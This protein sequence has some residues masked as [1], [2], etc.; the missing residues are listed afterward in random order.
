M[1]EPPKK[2]N[3]S[4]YRCDT[5]F[6]LDPILEMFCEENLIGICLVSGEELRIYTISITGTHI[7]PNLLRVIHIKLPN[8][9]KKGGQS[10]VRFGRIA[11]IVRS[12]YVT[13]FVESIIESYMTEN[14][15]KSIISKLII[16]GFGYMP[17]DIIDNHSFKQYFSKYFLKKMSIN[18]IDDTTV[19]KI[20]KSLLSTLDENL[21]KT[22][23]KEIIL[24]I[25]NNFETIGFGRNECMNCIESG[26]IIK[27]YINSSQVDKEIRD[28]FIDK[29]IL[30]IESTSQQLELYGGWLCVKKYLTYNTTN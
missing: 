21:S 14:K 9:Q 24:L 2:I 18:G 1:F 30:L 7:E 22:I 15:T 11:D 10:A 20:A 28:K 17:D 29:N 26:N 13:K 5:K 23:D 12:Q 8:K 6:Y 27:L 16:G 4:F 19:L 3:V 25:E